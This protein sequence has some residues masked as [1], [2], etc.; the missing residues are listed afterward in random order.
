MIIINIKKIDKNGNI[1]Y[2]KHDDGYEEFN[3]YDSTNKIIRSESRYANGIIEI[4]YYK[5]N[6]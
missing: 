6:D 3:E 1:I 5:S 2:E 4:E